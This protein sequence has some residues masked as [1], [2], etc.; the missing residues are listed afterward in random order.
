MPSGLP[1]GLGAFFL[2]GSLLSD[3]KFQGI[4]ACRKQG[5]WKGGWGKLHKCGWAGCW[6]GQ[7]AC[8]RWERAWRIRC[9]WGKCRA[10][11][12]RSKSPPY[13]N[14]SPPSPVPRSLSQHLPLHRCPLCRA[15]APLLPLGLG[16]PACRDSS[17]PYA[18]AQHA[19]T[20]RPPARPLACLPASPSTHPPACLP[21]CPPA[22]LRAG[23]PGVGKTT[24]IREIS[25]LLADECERR[26][27]IVDTS[28]EIG[29]HCGWMAGRGR[30]GA[31]GCGHVQ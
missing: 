6:W 12:V 5:C 13:T 3:S 18:A 23:R 16:E 17:S 26:V 25:R 4:C 27:V 15:A 14:P 8:K 28:N 1:S 22:C 31:V 19:L 2:T 30:Q 9:D 24:A 20:T 21:T 10:R 7:R 11:L 29:A